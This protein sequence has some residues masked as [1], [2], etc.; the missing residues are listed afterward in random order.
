MDLE[1]LSRH[2]AC[3]NDPSPVFEKHRSD[4]PLMALR[5]L[6]GTAFTLPTLKISEPRC[7]R[8]QYRRRCGEPVFWCSDKQGLRGSGVSALRL[9]Q[10]WFRG[11]GFRVLGLGLGALGIILFAWHSARKGFW[12]RVVGCRENPEPWPRGKVATSLQNHLSQLKP[13]KFW[14]L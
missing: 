11:L 9:G 10:A 8:F 4:T 1:V 7:R 3:W 14:W 2:S 5:L 13:L 6:A 12:R